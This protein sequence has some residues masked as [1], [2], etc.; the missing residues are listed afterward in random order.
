M[1]HLQLYLEHIRKGVRKNLYK[2]ISSFE[3]LLSATLKRSTLFG[4]EEYFKWR[5]ELKN[6]VSNSAPRIFNCKCISEV[7]VYSLLRSIEFVKNY[8]VCQEPAN[9]SGALTC[10][11]S[12][13]KDEL[14]T[15]K[16]QLRRGRAR[17]NER[18]AQP[19]DTWGRVTVTRV[20]Q[21]SLLTAD[22][23]NAKKCIY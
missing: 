1:E 12:T 14:V 21:I 23:D 5:H 22:T 13:A 18:E 9:Y 16:G 2:L 8:Q 20:R 15:V 11:V 6:L 10:G 17:K 4:G 3:K 19:A 7:M